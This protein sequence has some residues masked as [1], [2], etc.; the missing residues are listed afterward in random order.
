[1]KTD[2]KR[3]MVNVKMKCMTGDRRRVTDKVGRRS[4]VSGN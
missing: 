3:Q 4:F 2:V 1:M